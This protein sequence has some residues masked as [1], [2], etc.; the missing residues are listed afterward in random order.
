MYIM[1]YHQVHSIII[2]NYTLCNSILHVYTQSGLPTST[3]NIA[4]NSFIG[5]LVTYLLSNN[6]MFTVTMKLNY[7]IGMAVYCLWITCTGSVY[8]SAIQFCNLNKKM[9]IE[10]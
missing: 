8:L 5:S 9:K 1:Q 6:T 7:F 4:N 10:N 3:Y 2:H